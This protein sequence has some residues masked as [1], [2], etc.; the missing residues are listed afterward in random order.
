MHTLSLKVANIGAKGHLRY[1]WMTQFLYTCGMDNGYCIYF[2]EKPYY[3][4]SQMNEQLLAL[5]D[6][7][8]TILV[9]Q[10]TPA[11]VVQAIHDL[12]RTDAEAAIILT[13]RL[14]YYWQIFKEQFTLIDAAGGLVQDE[15][16]RPLF[17]Y[18][19]GM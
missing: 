17:I 19:R 11:A 13:N 7:G 12:E 9:N 14:E 8:G 6:W 2:G 4:T 1:G 3:I 18:R 16:G 10:P 15:A 5:T